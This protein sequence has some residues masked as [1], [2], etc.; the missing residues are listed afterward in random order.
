MFENIYR[1]V[2]V[3]TWPGW[4]AGP[5]VGCYAVCFFRFQRRNLGASSGFAA[6]IESARGR[7][8]LDFGRLDDPLRLPYNLHDPA[9]RWR[10][11]WLAGLL[12][13]GLLAWSLGAEGTGGLQLPGLKAGFPGWPLWAKAAALFGGGML[14]GFGTRMSGGCTSGHAIFGISQRQMPSVYATLV[15]FA[16]GMAFTIVWQRWLS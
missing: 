8:E 13:A 15:F 4:I 16:V 9:P 6:V 5:L 14:I 2:F 10:V 7:D 12:V 11:W 1:H 3:N